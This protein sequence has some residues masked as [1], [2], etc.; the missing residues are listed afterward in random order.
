MK[1]IVLAITFLI[2]GFNAAI[3]QEDLPPYTNKAKI[4]WGEG[5][6]DVPKSFKMV[7]VIGSDDSHFYVVTREKNWRFISKY[8][9]SSELVQKT[10]LN[11]TYDGKY[12]DFQFVVLHHGKLFMF[13]SFKHHKEKV[14]HLYRT[15][16]DL[17]TLECSERQTIMGKIPY[18]KRMSTGEF[19]YRVSLD[20]SKLLLFYQLVKENEPDANIVAT[21]FDEKM[22]ELWS[23][24]VRFPVDNDMF[25][26]TSAVVDND[27]SIYVAGREYPE[28]I[29]GRNKRWM[30]SNEY[31]YQVY[32]ITRE[33][34]KVR[35]FEL[36]GGDDM[37]ITDLALAVDENKNLVASGFYS[38]RG[39]SS[40][41]G[42]IFLRVDANTGE[43]LKTSR[44]EFTRDFILEG[45]SDRQVAK[46]SRK[47]ARGGAEPEM[48]EYDLSDFII[49][50]D[51]GCLLVA[52]QYFVRVTSTTTMTA[53]GGMQTHTT[54]HYYFNDI[55]V[56]N[57]NPQGHI[58]WNTRIPKRQYSVN[59]GGYRSS[60]AL[61]VVG[62]K[63]NFV[64]NDDPDNITRDPR[65]GLDRAKL[66]TNSMLALVQ[67]AADGSTTREALHFNSYR[68]GDICCVVP[69]LAHSLGDNRMLIV[70]VQ[71]KL[72]AFGVASFD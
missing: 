34:A 39:K 12:Q 62:D 54:Y 4:D 67:V 1:A 61:T 23:S 58:E 51:G 2:A 11:M 27:G 20:D 13:T 30:R 63:L 6:R 15:E 66:K 35:D 59:D 64:F 56:V 42:S 14:K 43:V 71:K 40:I 16:I 10:K 65:D 19:D 36:G 9:H 5:Y 44:K 21:V 57:I 3:A 52:E 18:Q 55:I 8:T 72:V 69:Q 37:I 38:E 49:R 60:Y 41:K 70:A 32:A 45:W 33:G 28:N 31:K 46:A 29:R 53:N 68:K 48:Y 22:E 24:T 47:E 50:E 17:T 7:Q 25:N 26:L